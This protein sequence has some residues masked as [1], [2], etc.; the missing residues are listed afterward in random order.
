MNHELQIYL[1][2]AVAAVP[3]ASL[4]ILPNAI[5]AEIIEKDGIF[6]CRD[7]NSGSRT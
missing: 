4:N 2:I 5:L 3:L 7:A 1:L 6:E